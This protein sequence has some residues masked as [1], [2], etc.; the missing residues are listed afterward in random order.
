MIDINNI[1]ELNKFF[2]SF[3]EKF[4]IGEEREAAEMLGGLLEDVEKQ[5]PDVRAGSVDGRGNISA[6]KDAGT[7]NISL[8]HVMEYYIYAYYFKPDTDVLCTEIPYGEYYRTY[9]GL[10]MQ[11]EKFNAAKKAYKRAI[12]W[13]PVD[14][15]SYLGLAEAYKNLNKLQKYITVTN[16]AYRYCCTRATMA[17]YYRNQAF[18]YLSSYKPEIARDC[19]LYSNVYYHTENADSELKYIEEAL[20]EETPKLDIKAVQKVF[21]ENGIEPGPDSDTIG[22]VYKVGEIMLKDKEYGLA[23]DCFS[24]VY[25]I[26]QEEQIENLL[27]SLEASLAQER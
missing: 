15:D 20:K 6:L 27:N 22:I 2:E 21:D 19:Y 24:I 25:D 17:R 23:R 7:C 9:A 8:N 26:T 16:N 5:L 18:Y 13:N 11:L 1:D 4:N 14:L 12:A 3:Q 10:C